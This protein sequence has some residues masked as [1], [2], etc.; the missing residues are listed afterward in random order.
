M[1]G[2]VAILFAGMLMRHYTFNNLSKATQE[3]T[4]AIVPFVASVSVVYVPL[5]FTRITL[6][7]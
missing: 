7:I 4:E 3:S 6:T 2:I 5:H 1:S